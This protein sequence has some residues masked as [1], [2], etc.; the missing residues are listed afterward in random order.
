MICQYIPETFF[1]SSKS[2]CHVRSPE[3]MIIPPIRDNL[4]GR[5]FTEH[6]SLVAV[7]HALHV[8]RQT[9]AP[10]CHRGCDSHHS[11]DNTSAL[12]SAARR[13]PT[14]TT[15]TSCSTGKTD[16]PPPTGRPRAG[17]STSE[18]TT[19]DSVKRPPSNAITDD[20][21]SNLPRARTP[22]TPTGTA[23]LSPS[24]T[25]ALPPGEGY[26]PAVQTPP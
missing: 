16:P 21:A 1:T 10:H 26:Y 15:N 22:R 3:P 14:H 4:S 25:G 18:A 17:I 9:L 2:R 19:N 20:S 12:P 11:P 5:R 6:C 23:W 7:W 13:S 8:R 24:S